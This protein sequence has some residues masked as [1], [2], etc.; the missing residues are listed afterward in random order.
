LNPEPGL[1][2]STVYELI[3]RAWPQ[4]GTL[5]LAFTV[6]SW[7]VGTVRP[8]IGFFPFLSLHGEVQSGKSR[9][10][11]M[12]NACQCLDEEGIPMSKLNTGKG[13]IRKLAQRSGIFVAML[14]ANN[15]ERIRFDLDT[16]LTRYNH[17]NP[18][19]TR[20]RKTNGLE[21]LE[22]P[23]RAALIFAQ[24]IEPFRTKAQNERVVSTRAFLQK[25]ITA[26]SK[27]AHNELVRTPPR[28][29]AHVFVEIMQRRREIETSWESEYLRA[30]D[31]VFEA[32][33]DNR[34]SENHGLILAFHRILCR[35]L[36]VSDDLTEFI[37]ELARE[38]RKRCAVRPPSLADHFFECLNE[39]EDTVAAQCCELRDGKLYI[40]LP[41]ALKLLE[42]RGL[43]L[44]PSFLIKDLRE[45]EGFVA[46]N[47]SY[48]GLFGQ[49]TASVCKTWCFE[50]NKVFS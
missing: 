26:E 28:K 46:G 16:L 32:M 1:E 20:A 25:D 21:T 12:L 30:R 18:L 44:N 4:N 34:L 10:V 15:V 47:Y 38:K 35:V 8:T 2:G 14:E 22:V 36:N 45:H 41:S 5:A 17:G 7:F 50:S 40:K 6:A 3:S 48:R 13:E 39:L 9:L 29:L 42:S 23:F 37:I 31:E 24:N 11:R 19:Q 49:R 33:Q 27:L 43:N